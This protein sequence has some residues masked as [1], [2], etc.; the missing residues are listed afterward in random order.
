M[1]NDY[2][3]LQGAE[4]LWSKIVSTFVQKK[5]IGDYTPTEQEREY[6]KEYIL[7]LENIPGTE[8]SVVFDPP[9][10]LKSITHAAGNDVVR[11]DTFTFGS[12]T[13]TEVRQLPSGAKLTIVTNLNT[14]VT[15]T[16]YTGGL[17]DG[18]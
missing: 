18:S 4:Y 12:N 5:D 3:D 8:Q 6:L 1:A 11:T 14:L 9:G 15:Q 13:I 17:S 2:L 10:I 7:H 16:T